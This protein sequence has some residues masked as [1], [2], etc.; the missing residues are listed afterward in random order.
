VRV[1]LLDGE[2]WALKQVLVL[3]LQLLQNRVK[4]VV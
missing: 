4:V 1:V 2:S 3:L